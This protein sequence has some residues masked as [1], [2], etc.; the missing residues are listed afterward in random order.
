L[1]TWGGEPRPLHTRIV[2]GFATTRPGYAL[3]RAV[4]RVPRAVGGAARPRPRSG[5]RGSVRNVLLVSHGDATTNSGL[6]VLAIAEELARRGFSPTAAFPRRGGA[7]APFAVVS[8]ADATRGRLL[9]VDGRGADLVHAFTPR[10]AV[11]RV[12]AA[13]GSPY[14]VHLEDDD[15][16]IVGSTTAAER[17]AF[18]ARSVGVTVVVERLLELKPERLPAV[19]AW[20]GFDE[21]VL[22]PRRD[23][24]ELR[25]LLG[26]DD[27]TTVLLYNGNIHETNLDDMRELYAAVLR[28]REQGV[29]A[30]LVKCGLRF[31]PRSYLP[32]LGSAIRDLGWVYRT[33]IPDLLHAA[34]VLVQ[35]GSPGSYDDYRFPSKLPE[36]LASGRP[37][38]LPRTNVGLQLRNAEEA[39]LLDAGDADEIAARVV[40]LARDPTLRARVGQAGRG[41]ALRELR[42]SRAVD[43]VVELYGQV[44]EA[45]QA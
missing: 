38:V 33:H 11:V 1:T 31:V 41:F 29:D 22:A 5:P 25:R 7:A 34:D 26:V 2:H 6:H 28:V 17:D 36:F 10:R 20:P 19:V 16:Q 37:V 12:T 45:P 18:L 44:A 39:L 8:H 30:V 13:T 43:R 27:D 24:G 4:R 9:F 42:W 21:A 14:V 32:R 23:R 40:E 35:P 15:A 3:K